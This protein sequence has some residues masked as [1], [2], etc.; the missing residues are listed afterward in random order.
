M[1]MLGFNTF[2]EHSQDIIAS[3]HNMLHGRD[4]D[5]LSRAQNEGSQLL[6]RGNII[7]MMK[8]PQCDWGRGK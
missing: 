6:M 4:S 1:I 5:K 7:I 2:I 8:V 3:S